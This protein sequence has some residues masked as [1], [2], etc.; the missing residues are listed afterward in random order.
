MCPDSRNAQNWPKM[1]IPGSLATILEQVWLT[2]QT[3]RS[4]LCVWPM[5]LASRSGSYVW[6]VRLADES[7][8]KVWLI[9]PAYASGR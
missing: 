7:G 3:C 8:V 6:L 4:G 1:R 2:S 5:S 9:C